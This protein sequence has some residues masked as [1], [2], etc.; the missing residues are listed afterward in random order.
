MVNMINPLRFEIFSEN[1]VIS[2][3]EAENDA[4]LLII[5]NSI[6]SSENPFRVTENDIN[7]PFKLNNVK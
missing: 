6:F 5:Q 7:F 3:F 2:E 4:I 1:F